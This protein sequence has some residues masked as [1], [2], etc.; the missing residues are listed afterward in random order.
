M[1][2]DDRSLF[3]AIA[4]T[5]HVTST[6]HPAGP[7]SC[8]FSVEVSVSEGSGFTFLGD[9][10]TI[11]LYEDLHLDPSGGPGFYFACLDEALGREIERVLGRTFLQ[12]YEG[13][14]DSGLGEPS[15]NS[16]S[17]EVDRGSPPENGPQ[18]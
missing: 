16:T 10:P 5:V 13:S 8:G 2:L 4:D 15:D 6:Y 11:L 12:M 7:A 17:W 18:Q 9:G 14:C 3:R 1:V